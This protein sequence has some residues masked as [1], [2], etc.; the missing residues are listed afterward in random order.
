MIASTAIRQ[1]NYVAADHP[2]A[3]GCVF[4]FPSAGKMR[5]RSSGCF[6]RPSFLALRHAVCWTGPRVSCAGRGEKNDRREVA[7]CGR[8]RWQAA[9]SQPLRVEEGRLNPPFSVQGGESAHE[10]LVCRLAPCRVL[11]VVQHFPCRGV[12]VVCRRQV[13]PPRPR[14]M[15]FDVRF[16]GLPSDGTYFRSS[17]ECAWLGKWLLSCS[18]MTLRL[19]RWGVARPSSVLYSPW[20]PM[21]RRHSPRGLCTI[22]RSL[23]NNFG[24][25]CT[26]AKRVPAELP[27]DSSELGG[28]AHAIW[29]LL[30]CN[31]SAVHGG[32]DATEPPPGSRVDAIYCLVYC[33]GD[34]LEIKV[35]SVAPVRAVCAL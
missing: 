20:K 3:V 26:R 11:Q 14:I 10:R 35:G 29:A 9:L 30:V 1:A 23:H 2:F 22:I 4:G 12:F 19:D 8:P 31:G 21:A 28:L 7:F 16:L 27:S 15:G 18:W 32:S 24:R 34:L 33:H 6:L 17:A 5:G 13:P 25:Q